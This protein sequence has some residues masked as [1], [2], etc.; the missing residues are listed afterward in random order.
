MVSKT[1]FCVSELK[2]NAVKIGN[3]SRCCKFLSKDNVVLILFATNPLWIGKALKQKQ[4]RRPAIF[5]YLLIG[6]FREER[7]NNEYFVLIFKV[8]FH[9]QRLP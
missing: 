2:G 4:V 8:N 5:V 7:L 6:S 1:L 3:S 9:L